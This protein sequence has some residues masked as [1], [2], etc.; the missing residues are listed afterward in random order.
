MKRQ[1]RSSCLF[2]IVSVDDESYSSDAL[3][4]NRQRSKSK[5]HE[6][7]YS[8]YVNRTMISLPSQNKRLGALMSYRHTYSIV[9]I[10]GYIAS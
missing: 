1:I 4:K 8:S 9:W 3:E 7:T 10:F 6:I 2:K 5:S